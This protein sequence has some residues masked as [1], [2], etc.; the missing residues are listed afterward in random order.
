MTKGI[1]ALCNAKTK[2]S[3]FQELLKII[4][5]NSIPLKTTLLAQLKALTI[6]YNR[7]PGIHTSCN[8]D[9]SIEYVSAIKEKLEK[10]KLHKATDA[11][12]PL[13]KTN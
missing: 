13:R 7:P 8:P 1:C 6:L 2:W 4:F 11:Q 9:I 5:D 12:M 10:R 3:Y